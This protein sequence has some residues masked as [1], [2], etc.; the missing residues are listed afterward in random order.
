MAKPE[1]PMMTL[2]NIP[3][4]PRRQPVKVAGPYR[5][6]TISFNEFLISAVAHIAIAGILAYAVLGMAGAWE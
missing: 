2:Q 1:T 5:K 3:N 6:Q 4:Q